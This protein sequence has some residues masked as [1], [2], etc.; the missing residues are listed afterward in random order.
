M[1]AIRSKKAPIRYQVIFCVSGEAQ[2]EMR[3]EEFNYP[4]RLRL[5][6]TLKGRE[7]ENLT[8]EEFIVWL[9][10]KCVA[11]KQPLV[12]SSRQITIFKASRVGKFDVR[13]CEV[14]LPAKTSLPPGLATTLAVSKKP[15]PP[16]R[17]GKQPE[18]IY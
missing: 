14:R 18:C 3:S 1:F 13:R 15:I 17:S 4:G 7:D 6:P 2:K 9:Q 10:K 5:W 8:R 11:R 16:K 12:I